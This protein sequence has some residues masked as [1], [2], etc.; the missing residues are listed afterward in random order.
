MKRIS[1]GAEAVIYQD[2]EGI[3]KDRIQK[4]YRL[5]EIDVRL[6]KFRTRR[7]AKVLERLADMGFPAPRLIRMDDVQMQLVMEKVPGEKL[8]NVLGQGDYVRLAAEIGRKIAL[9]HN[10]HIIHGDLTTSNMILNTGVYFIDFGLSFFSHKIEDKAVDLHLFR[11]ALDSTHYR[12]AGEC[13]SAA[14][15]AYRKE[16]K[17]GEAVLQRLLVVEKRGRYKQGS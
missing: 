11:Q 7:E 6:R 13:W 4:S 3:R 15:E 9:L 14:A 8:R 10:R 1:Q 2:G 5:P 12:I 17:E 16:A